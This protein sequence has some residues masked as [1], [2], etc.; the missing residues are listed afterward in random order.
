LLVQQYRTE[1]IHITPQEDLT[2]DEQQRIK[3]LEAALSE[4]ES[5]SVNFGLA[6][7]ETLKFDL[8][9]Q[10]YLQKGYLPN[11]T[12]A[13]RKARLTLGLDHSE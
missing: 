12:R 10:A 2:M 6:V 8:A 5:A 1:W 9:G 7:I 13:V 4:L 3:E 11:L